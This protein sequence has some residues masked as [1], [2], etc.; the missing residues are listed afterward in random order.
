MVHF[1]C[2]T[3]RRFLRQLSSHAGHHDS[4]HKSV[5]SKLHNR[6]MQ[7]TVELGLESAIVALKFSL[8]C[9]SVLAVVK[10]CVREP[11]G[12][13]EPPLNAPVPSLLHQARKLF[14]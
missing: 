12:H 3:F 10:T 1:L 9:E 13:L 4:V 14:F 6:I 5:T 8:I 11:R 7:Q 2:V